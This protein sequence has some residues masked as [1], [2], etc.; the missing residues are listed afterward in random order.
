[1]PTHSSQEPSDGP[2]HEPSKSSEPGVMTMRI[3]WSEN[4]YPSQDTRTDYDPAMEELVRYLSPPTRSGPTTSALSTFFNEDLIK[5]FW[6]H[7]RLGTTLLLGALLFLCGLWM[8][9]SLGSASVPMKEPPEPSTS[10]SGSTKDPSSTEPIRSRPTQ[11]SGSE[12]DNWM[13]LPST[14][15]DCPGGSRCRRWVPS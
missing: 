1:M 7:G 3:E 15:S 14:N 4:F 11:R 10:T 2:E 5:T 12:K 13:P 8:G 9:C 6:P